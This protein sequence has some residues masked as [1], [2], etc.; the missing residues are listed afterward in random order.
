MRRQIL[1]GLALALGIGLLSSTQ[2][3]AY[4]GYGYYLPRAYGNSYYRARA[5][6]YYRPRF[7]RAY[8]GRYYRGWW[9]PRWRYR[10]FN[11]QLH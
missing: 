11:A 9:G 1:F 6:G 4:K 8:V 5:Y 2:A 3:S 10:A 7:Y